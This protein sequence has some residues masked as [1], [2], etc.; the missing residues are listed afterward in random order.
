MGVGPNIAGLN[1]FRDLVAAGRAYRCAETIQCVVSLWDSLTCAEAEEGDCR[2]CGSIS[3]NDGGSNRVAWIARVLSTNGD[4]VF[5]L[6]NV[7]KEAPG[8]FSYC[9]EFWIGREHVRLVTFSRLESFRIL[10]YGIT[11]LVEDLFM[12]N[13]TLE[14]DTDLQIMVSKE[15]AR[16][17]S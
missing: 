6:F 7:L 13:N 10:N 8:L 12:G 2:T 4:T 17:D 14:S 3:V 16:G 15:T 11:G 9:M 1:L 5:F